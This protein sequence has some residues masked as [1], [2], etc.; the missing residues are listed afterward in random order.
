MSLSLKAIVGYL[1]MMKK[2]KQAKNVTFE[3]YCCSFSKT[4]HQ[5]KLQKVV[6]LSS[7][8]W[9]SCGNRKVCQLLT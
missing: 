4:S 3:L 2:F 1:C 6:F 9:L 5:V 7:V 8:D